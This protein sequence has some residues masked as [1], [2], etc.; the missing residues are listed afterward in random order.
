MCTG[1]FNELPFKY[2]YTFNES[3]SLNQGVKLKN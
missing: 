2:M 1:H 3:N